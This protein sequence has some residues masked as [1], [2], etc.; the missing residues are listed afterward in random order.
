MEDYYGLPLE[1][2]LKSS[3]MDAQISV[4]VNAALAGNRDE[5]TRT[6]IENYFGM[7]LE[8]VLLG[9]GG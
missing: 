1:S 5:K 4:A 9:Y 7:P 6:V 8:T 2:V 3:Y